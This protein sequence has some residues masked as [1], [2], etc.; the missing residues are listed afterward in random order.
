MIGV[1][2]LTVAMFL[3]VFTCSDF[4]SFQKYLNTKIMLC[5]CSIYCI[6]IHSI[7]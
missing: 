2:G 5:L 1:K 6:C 4:V 3:S 7:A